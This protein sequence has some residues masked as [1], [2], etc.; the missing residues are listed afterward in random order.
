MLRPEEPVVK[1]AIALKTS[2]SV[3]KAAA[4]GDLQSEPQVF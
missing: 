4:R 1:G 2:E 3:E